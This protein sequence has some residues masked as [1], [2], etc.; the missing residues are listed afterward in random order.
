MEDVYKVHEIFSSI[1]GEGPN[2]GR[3]CTFVRFYGCNL[4]CHFC[5]TPQSN[6]DSIPYTTDTLIEKI[7]E[8]NTEFIVFTGGEPLLQL[9]SNLLVRLAARGKVVG[10]ETNGTVDFTIEDANLIDYITVSPK[11]LNLARWLKPVRINEM[12]ILV[13][14]SG[15]IVPIDIM[16]LM[17]EPVVI[18]LSPVWEEDHYNL[19]ALA[20]ALNI[21]KQYNHVGMRLSVQTHK[22]LNLK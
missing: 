9:K 15:P 18:T 19:A 12:R 13:L 6:F 16:H 8:E 4:K 14:P 20:K 2:T 21:L 1:Q 22:L 5:D 11:T 7:E 10:V 3:W 17:Y